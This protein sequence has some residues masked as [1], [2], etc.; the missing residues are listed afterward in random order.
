MLGRAHCN[1]FWAGTDG[2]L[3]RSTTDPH[4]E[5]VQMSTNT[6]VVTR[7]AVDD[8]ENHLWHQFVW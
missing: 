4:S 1:V 3:W 6:T 5:F 7:I 8:R 2:T